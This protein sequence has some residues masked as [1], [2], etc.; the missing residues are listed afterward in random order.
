MVFYLK[1]NF[2]IILKTLEFWGF[3]LFFKMHYGT[4]A[5]KTGEWVLLG[6]YNTDT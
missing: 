2:Y 4:Q 1:N 6:S 5:L 3:Y